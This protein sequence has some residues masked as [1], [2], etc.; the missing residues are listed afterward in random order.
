LYLQQNLKRFLRT[1]SVS[2]GCSR[3]R[4]CACP[5]WRL[6]CPASASRRTPLQVSTPVHRAPMCWRLCWGHLRGRLRL[7]YVW[8]YGPLPMCV[9]AW[10]TMCPS[11]MRCSQQHLDRSILSCSCFVCSIDGESGHAVCSVAAKPHHP[12]LVLHVLAIHP[13]PLPG[14][15]PW[16][17]PRPRGGWGWR[18]RKGGC[19]RGRCWWWWQQVR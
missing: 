12:C 8:A 5:A 17:A 4:R 10:V 14:L 13:L 2:F 11:T 1:S 18:W 3:R 16:W 7:R 19:P 15:P 6:S 9:H